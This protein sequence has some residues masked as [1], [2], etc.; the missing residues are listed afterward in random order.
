M[1]EK[2]NL[3]SARNNYSQGVNVSE[4]KPLTST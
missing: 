2:I 4:I 3:I 1:Y